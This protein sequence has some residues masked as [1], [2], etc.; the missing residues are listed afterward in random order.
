MH[1]EHDNIERKPL[2]VAVITVSD[3]RDFD[4]DKG[5]KAVIQHLADINISVNKAYYS[6]VKDDQAEIRKVIQHL[7]H[8]KVDVIITTGGT[9]IAKRDVTIEVV[10]SV[11]DKEMEGFGEIFRFLS[12]TEDVGPRAILSRAICGTKDNTVIFSIPGSV[13]AVNLAMKKLITQ[14]IHHI[15]HELTK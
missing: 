14:Q 4:T 15:V 9:G 5:G 12:Y 13:G 3:T 1:N 2:K 6:I 11:I 8:E 10:K 7:L